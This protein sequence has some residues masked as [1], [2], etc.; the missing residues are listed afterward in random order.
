MKKSK[1][2][3]DYYLK[4]SSVTTI[5]LAIGTPA[6]LSDWFA[7]NVR[8]EG[9]QYIFTWDKNEQ[10]ATLVKMRSQAYIRWQWDEEAESDPECYFEMS[11]SVNELTG[12]TMLHVVDF[13]AENE[14]EETRL[15][16]N[17]QVE[18]MMRVYGF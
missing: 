9:K 5:W 12:D 18:S 2:E 8:I 10:A 13:A 11:I 16:W 15:W 4:N 14:S 17:Q 1:I 3:L 7:D 6:G